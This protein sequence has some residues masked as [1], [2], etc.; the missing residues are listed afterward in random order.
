MDENISHKAAAL[1]QRQNRRDQ[2]NG[3]ILDALGLEACTVQMEMADVEQVD[4]AIPPPKCTECNGTKVVKSLFSKWECASCFGT[5][6]DL[7]NPI[8]VIKWQDACLAWSK[9][10]ITGLRQKVREMSDTRTKEEKESD[11][12]DA[13]YH[14]AKIKD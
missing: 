7:S 12:I 6:F 10:E 13:F 3:S 1:A 9:R 11:A 14:D 4:I 5:G 2:Q 8:A